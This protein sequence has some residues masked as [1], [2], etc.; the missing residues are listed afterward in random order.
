MYAMG[1]V[2]EVNELAASA[3][4]GMIGHAEEET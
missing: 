1:P 3:V 4:N 2:E